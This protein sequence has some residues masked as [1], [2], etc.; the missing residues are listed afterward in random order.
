LQL[1]LIAQGFGQALVCPL[2]LLH[3]RIMLRSGD[4]H[5]HAAAWFQAA[6]PS[7]FAP[8]LCHPITVMP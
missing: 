1:Q 5:R 6:W 2:G 7:P 8:I 3:Q 4:P